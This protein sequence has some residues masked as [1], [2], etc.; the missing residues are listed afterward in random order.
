M[1]DPILRL[2]KE[3][4][5][6]I[7]IQ[8]NCYEKLWTLCDFGT[9]FAGTPGEVLA[10]NFIIE[11]LDDYGFEV[12]CEPF[13]HLGWKR[14]SAKLEV[15]SPIKRELVTIS[16][17]GGP[18]TDIDG[19]SGELINVGNGTPGEFSN[20]KRDIKDNIVLSTSLSPRG[21]CN[22]PRQ[23]H[24]R[25][26]Y[27]RAVEF[28]AKAFIFMNSQPGMLPQ[29]GSLRQN[30]LGEIPAVTVPYEEGILL[31]R[32]LDKGKVK[33]NISVQNESFDNKTSN[34]V[35]EIPGKHDDEIIIIGAHYDCHDDSPG[36]LDNG[37][38]ITTLLELSRIFSKSNAKFEKTIRFIFFG[39]EEIG[40][41]GSSFYVLEHMREH[42]NIH[43]MINLDSPGAKGGKTF[44]VAGFD[45]VYEYIQKISKDISYPMKQSGP[46]FGA[47]QVPF[48]LRGIPTA[49][50]R[51][52][53]SPG[54]FS[55]QGSLN[56]EDRGWGHT[57]GDTPDKIMPA[58][59]NEGAIIAGRVLNRAANQH[60][61]IAEHRTEG[62]IV[63]ILEKHGMD[64]V[65]HYM[66]W[67]NIPIWP[68]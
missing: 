20:K 25:T 57:P 59:I 19:L 7:L 46:A 61:K 5:S 24:R 33:V 63:N 39:V 35:V 36:A 27:G 6:E 15:I 40:C 43:L 66:K 50:M 23:C 13:T 12:T 4:I 41:V 10:R 56:F 22:P 42:S 28:G 62:E 67:P 60:G 17:A 9:R 18:S 30:I 8:N 32:L 11:E 21:Q 14:G 38:G 16:L 47:D 49:M 37:T 3:I 1:I 2:D 52:S 26:K 45:D 51:K 58:Q 55:Y 48:F 31:Q 29:T 44:D 53:E 54:L 64:E 68:W 65:L 34:I